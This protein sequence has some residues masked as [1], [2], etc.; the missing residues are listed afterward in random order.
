MKKEIG[1]SKE[2]AKCG[3]GPL[4]VESKLTVLTLTVYMM[5]I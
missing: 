5:F 3:F 4:K 1:Y 2:Y